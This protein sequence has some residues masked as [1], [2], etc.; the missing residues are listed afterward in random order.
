MRIVKRLLKHNADVTHEYYYSDLN[1][2]GEAVIKG[3]RYVH[4][5]VRCVSAPV[6]IC[7]QYCNKPHNKW[8]QLFDGICGAKKTT[9]DAVWL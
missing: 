8:F 4:M 6:Y 7:K 2:L 9:N 1:C 3:H 5:Y